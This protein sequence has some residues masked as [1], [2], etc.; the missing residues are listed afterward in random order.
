MDRD[1]QGVRFFELLTP[2]DAAG[3]AGINSPRAS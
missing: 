3:P 2:I 1:Q